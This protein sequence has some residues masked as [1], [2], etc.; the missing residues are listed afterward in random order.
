MSLY[1]TNI[2][3]RYPIVSVEWFG[4]WTEENGEGLRGEDW[5]DATGNLKRY[6]RC[7]GGNGWTGNPYRG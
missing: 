1:E 4:I 2:D 5:R 3:W 6:Y 7:G